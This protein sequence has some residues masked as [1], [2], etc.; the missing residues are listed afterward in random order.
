MTRVA[1]SGRPALI[2]VVA[3]LVVSAP[4]IAAPHDDG[5]GRTGRPPDADSAPA[6]D[7]DADS[8]DSDYSDDI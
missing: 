6:R 5:T 3:A 1:R 8:D 4:T 7:D 2:G